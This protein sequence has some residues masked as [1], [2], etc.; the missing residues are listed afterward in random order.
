M[1]VINMKTQDHF[2]LFIVI[3]LVGNLYVGLGVKLQHFPNDV[4]II[5]LR[6]RIDLMAI[7]IN[8]E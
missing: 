1:L 7:I 8:Y 4:V 3:A 2:K 6:K 5:F